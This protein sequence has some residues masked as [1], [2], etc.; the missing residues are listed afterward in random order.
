MNTV[1]TLN[2]PARLQCPVCHTTDLFLP[3][4]GYIL[5]RDCHG[6]VE[7]ASERRYRGT[8][9]RLRVRHAMTA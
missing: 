9:R 6:T 1:S 8:S 7:F 4:P 5:C 2:Q 3:R